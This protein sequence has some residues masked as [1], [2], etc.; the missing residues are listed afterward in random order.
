MTNLAF[1]LPEGVRSQV[2]DDLSTKVLALFVF[3]EHV[4]VL[5][6][7]HSHDVSGNVRVQ[8]EVHE[9]VAEG[10][11]LHSTTQDLNEKP[12]NGRA[13]AVVHRDVRAGI[14]RHT[15]VHLKFLSR[16]STNGMTNKKIRME[17]GGKMK[18]NRQSI[19]K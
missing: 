17:K 1:Q 4:E 14:G 11:R 7:H 19:S 18:K 12:C 8:Y 16:I 15:P 10:A 5:V 6:V 2:L 9:R 3:A 13:H